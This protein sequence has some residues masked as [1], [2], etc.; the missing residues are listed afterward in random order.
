[1]S[2]IFL[3]RVTERNSQI[4]LFSIGRRM[5]TASFVDTPLRTKVPSKSERHCRR[6]DQ[7]F[8]GQTVLRSFGPH[9]AEREALS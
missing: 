8:L 7:L 1:V 5:V 4:D 2:E 9:N 3:E 6:Y